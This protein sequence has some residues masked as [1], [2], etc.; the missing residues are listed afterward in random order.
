MC[1]ET[2]SIRK[3]NQ[4]SFEVNDWISTTEITP[5]PGEKY[6]TAIVKKVLEHGSLLKITY[7][8]YASEATVHAKTCKLLKRI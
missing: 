1:T 6:I 8:V 7:G 5:N 4:T 2:F 3:K